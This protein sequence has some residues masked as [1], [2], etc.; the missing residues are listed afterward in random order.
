MATDLAARRRDFPALAVHIHGHRLAYLD[1]AATSLK[2]QAV[3]DAV[4]HVATH[5]AGNPHRSVH[6]LAEAAALAC[7][8]ARADVA[9]WLGADP[10]EIVFTSGTTASLNLVAQAWGR[11]NVGPGDAIVATE[12]EHHSN[13]VPWQMLCAERGAELRIASVDDA[14]RIDFDRVSLAGAKLV[15]VAHVSNVLGTVAPIA[16]LA[17]RAHA[18]GA[19]VVVDGAQAV[20][21]LPIDVRALGCDFYAFSAHKMYGPPGTGVLWGRAELLAAMP[22]WQ[23]GGGM[24]ASVE[25]QSARYREPPARFEA[26]TPNISGIA[27][28]AAAVRYLGTVDRSDEPRI[29][30]RLVDVIAAAGARILGTPELGVVSFVMPRVHAHD[31]ATICDG[32]GVA[33]RSGHHCAQPLHRRF[34]VDASARASVACYSGDDDVAQLAAALAKVR[35]VF[36]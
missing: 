9:A 5:D 28:L 21:H 4:T 2:P 29:H 24:I 12:L 35:E 30:A 15:A 32:E 34:G 31:V 1:S 13:L 20:A 8:G 27:G 36:P 10:H 11:A 23:G 16:E 6:A 7:D 22:P 14:G 25:L 3:I 33:V 26:G 18:A 17:R 19:V